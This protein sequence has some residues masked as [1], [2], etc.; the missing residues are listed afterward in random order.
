[1]LRPE[2]TVVSN[3]NLSRRQYNGTRNQPDEQPVSRQSVQCAFIELYRMGPELP[4]RLCSKLE[5]DRTTGAYAR[6]GA[7][8]GVH[9]FQR[10]EAVLWQQCE[11][12]FPC[13]WAFGIGVT[14]VA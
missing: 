7:R 10:D 5:P 6:P 14:A 8:S 11:P 13:R 4:G 3:K 12:G 9:W 2:F 1:W